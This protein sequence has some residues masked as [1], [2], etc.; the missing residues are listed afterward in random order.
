MSETLIAPATEQPITHRPNEITISAEQLQSKMWGG[1]DIPLTQQP[2]VEEPPKV[3]DKP[4]VVE[5]PKVETSIWHKDFGWESEEVAKTEIAALK[6]LKDAP[7]TKEEIKFNN[8]TSKQVHEL[9]REGKIDDVVDI[10]ATQKKIEKATTG[11]ITKDNASDILKLKIQLSNKLLTKED[12]DF[13]YNR[14]FVAPKEPVQKT[15][16]S[17]EEFQERHDEWKEVAAMV[18]RQR[19]VAAKMAIPELEK[20]KT[21]IVLPT[22]STPE[23]QLKQPTQE[24]LDADKKYDEAYIQSVDT[25]LKGFNGFSVMV[26]NEAVGLPET[27]IAYVAMDTEKAALDQEMKNFSKAKYNTNE[28]FADRWVNEDRSLNT[29]QITEDRFLLL[30]RDKIF[31][32]LAD[33]AANKAVDAYIKGKKQI[34]INLTNQQGTAVINQEDKTEMDVLRDKFF[35]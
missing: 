21:Q 31:Q 35:G 14:E 3:E 18:E 29:K 27:A 32:K 34:D 7:P 1:D 28:L 2:K 11:E 10:Y 25:S 16:E 26:K 22:I 30:N 20:L 19:I 15:I 17:D 8:D 4:A 33:E 12:V 23:V 24:K 9:L 13:Q 5:Q 6:K